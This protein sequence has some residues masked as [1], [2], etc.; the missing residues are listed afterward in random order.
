MMDEV[1]FYIENDHATVELLGDSHRVE[2]M[3]YTRLRV[4]LTSQQNYV[5]IT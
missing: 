3:V 1:Y 5:I 4:M 2:A